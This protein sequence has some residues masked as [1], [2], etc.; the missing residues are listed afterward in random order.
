MDMRPAVAF[1]S[2]EGKL[3]NM[4]AA[5]TNRIGMGYLVAMTSVILLAG[6]ATQRMDWNKRIG[7]YT[8]DQAVLEL[9]PPDKVANLQDGTIVAEWLTYRGYYRSHGPWGYSPYWYG[10]YYPSYYYDTY[11]PDYFIRL[12]FGSDARLKS[13]K[14]FTR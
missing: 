6:C 13:W 10:P 7:N 2:P 11:S 8:Y 14:K 12:I 4:D 9:G 1:R 5:R 3:E